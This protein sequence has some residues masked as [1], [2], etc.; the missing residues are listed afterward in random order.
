[1]F[2]KRT[3]WPRTPNRWSELVARAPGPMVDLTESNPTRCGLGAP[4]L[5]PL[6]ADARGATYQPEA[7]G[8]S[9]AREAVAAYYQKR[10]AYVPPGR[11]VLSASTSEAYGWLFKLLC[12]P[13]DVVLIPA[14]GYPLLPLLAELE[15]VRLA[16][17]PLVRD[18]GWRLNLGALERA[19]VE[20]GP[21]AI[22]LVHPGNPTGVF[23]RRDDAAAVA[24]L[25]RAHG[26]VLIVDEVFADYGIAPLPADRLPSFAR[27]TAAPHDPLIFVLSGLSKVALTPQLKLG[28][29]AVCGGS[30]AER[31]EAL[32][33]LELV[34]D[35]YLSVSTPVQLALPA[36]LRAAP[37]LQGRVRARVAT[38]LGTLDA[39]IA[40]GG[41]DTPLRRLPVDGGWYA[42]VQIPRTKTDDE[43]LEATLAEGVLVHPG[44]FFDLEGSGAMVVSLLP[45]EAVFAA[46]ISRAVRVW[47]A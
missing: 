3:A 30:E 32:A 27:G 19:L 46:A 23:T 34:A 7:L 5:I 11:I 1:M 14:P 10:G 28:W 15:E 47:A 41:R 21:R 40:A 37:G 44:Y 8:H 33:R 6:L 2:S 26:A 31:E 13:G 45:E 22:L 39:A 35:S 4:E 29:T 18:E 42:I 17:Y 16:T 20:R 24:A 43:W 38:N 25:A 9:D 12:D 36:I